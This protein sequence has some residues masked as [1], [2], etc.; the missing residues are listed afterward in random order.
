MTEPRFAGRDVWFG[1]VVRALERPAA[2]RVLATTAVDPGTVLAVA[3]IEASSADDG[4]ITMLS[5]QELA[6]SAG[7]SRSTVLRV[8]LALVEL[9]LQDAVAVSGVPGRVHRMLHH[10]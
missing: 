3:R 5:H 7:V 10:D 2:G 4:G 8:R 9:G 1:A 6:E